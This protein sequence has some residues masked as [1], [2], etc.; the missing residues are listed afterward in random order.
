MPPA[1]AGQGD[2]GRRAAYVQIPLLPYIGH[3]AA[4]LTA[5][6]LVTLP[7]Y[8]YADAELG[9]RAK[10]GGVYLGYGD[11]GY[12]AYA[13]VETPPAY[14]GDAELGWATSNRQV[15]RSAAAAVSTPE[16]VPAAASFAYQAEEIGAYLG[17]V[18]FS[19]VLSH[20]PYTMA[21]TLGRTATA[22]PASTTASMTATLGRAGSSTVSTPPPGV[23]GTPCCS[24]TVPAT[25][26]ATITSTNCACVTSYNPTLN[27][28]TSGPDAGKWTMGNVSNCNAIMLTIKFW[29]SSGP[30][31]QYHCAVDGW[32]FPAYDPS[33]HVSSTCNPFSQVFDGYP[34]T[35]S[36]GCP[37]GTFRVTIHA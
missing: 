34:T 6:A 36:V 22:P 7:P 33:P 25:L 11:L 35:A 19:D 21:A 2:A 5:T 31:T 32:S 8:E 3:G 27:Y 24:V 16:P 1:V 15:G 28:Q 9:L 10:Y 4:G 13:D 12:S 18:A 29:C 37:A 17:H 26:T 14:Q 23:P 20:Y 30:P